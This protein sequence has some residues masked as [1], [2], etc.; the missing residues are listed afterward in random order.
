[1]ND[2]GMQA[3]TTK[4]G[5]PTLIIGG[6]GIYH[7]DVMNC[8]TFTKSSF[9]GYGLNMELAQFANGD[10]VI[11]VAGT[12]FSGYTTI[13]VSVG[14]FSKSYNNNKNKNNNMNMNNIRE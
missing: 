9:T 5:L 14:Q 3:I 12:V 13:T 10:Y 2:N 7:C 8:T 4:D 6:V 1:M 11:A